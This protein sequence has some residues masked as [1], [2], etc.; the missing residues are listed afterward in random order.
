IPQSIPL[1]AGTDGMHANISRSLKQMFLTFRDQGI[2]GDQ[3]I[4]LIKKIYFDQIGFAKKYFPDFAALN[5][6]DRA[7]LIV[8]DYVPPTPMTNENFWGHFIFGMLEYP[9]H[10]VLQNGNFLMKDFQL[11]GVD[12]NKIKNEIYVQGE[13]LFNELQNF[14]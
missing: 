4:A 12:E 8:W 14:K 9:I 1:L 13:R 11:I 5:E 2:S 7:D 3:A 6:N 10:T